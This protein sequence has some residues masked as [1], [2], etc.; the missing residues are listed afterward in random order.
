MIDS[1]R[2]LDVAIL[3]GGLAGNL[4]ARQLRRDVPDVSV[5]V[6]EKTDAPRWKVGES[7]VEIASNYL[8]RKAGLATY[9]YDQHLPKN[10]LRF[11]FDTPE[12]D[13]ELTQMSEIG[14]DR[15]PPTPSFQLDR[16]RLEKDLREMN[17]KDGVDVL[18]GWT[19]RDVEI[20]EGGEPHRF[21]VVSED[22]ERRRYRARWL[23]DAT[24]RASTLARQLD[25]RIDEPDHLLAAV[26]GRYTNVR[27]IDSIRDDAWKRRTRHVARV[28]STNHFCYPGYWIWFIPLGRG[29][30]SVGLVGHKEIFRRG[31]R[32]QEGFRAFLDEHR[33]PSF[34][35]EGSTPLDLEGY[36]QLA[37]GTKQFFSE[38][39][40]GLLGDAG[41]FT[42]PFYS[43]GSDFIGIECDFLTDLI[44]RDRAGDAAGELAERTRTYDA[45]MRFRWEATMRIYRGLYSTFGSYELMKVKFNFDFGCYFNLWFDPFARDLHLDL[46]FLQG[47][48]RK[49]S[50]TLTALQNFADLF[51]R[52]E[53]D[54]R[55]RGAYHRG[56][57]GNYNVGVDTVRPLIDEV[58]TPRKKRQIDQRTEDIFNY[59]RDESLKLLERSDVEPRGPWRLYQFAD[60]TPLG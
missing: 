28:L 45:F 37:Y 22:G 57:L 50:E 23:I 54:L 44:K 46:K 39:R 27:D 1:E 17:V 21:T 24:G 18:V 32:T 56:N 41:A 58:T 35:M 51:R 36:T 7:T 47:E 26:W 15:P 33:A 4:M 52:V 34:L 2:V 48:L 29:V 43:P 30:T 53:A 13:A 11:F 60:P 20:G 49:Q 31:I 6:F 55:A 40:W 25:L 14:T 3:G 42:D 5:G 16:A 12:K 59:G 8:V 19:A 10:G 38:D 9:L